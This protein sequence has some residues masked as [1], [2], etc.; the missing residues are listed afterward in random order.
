MIWYNIKRKTVSERMNSAMKAG[1]SIIKDSK[2]KDE[3][4]LSDAFQH[5]VKVPKDSDMYKFMSKFNDGQISLR[6]IQLAMDSEEYQA[7]KD[8]FEFKTYKNEFSI[9][10]QI[11]TRVSF[12]H[13]SSCQNI[14]GKHIYEYPNKQIDIFKFLS[15]NKIDMLDDKSA[16][17]IS[18]HS[19]FIITKNSLD[20]EFPYHAQ[21]NIDNYED[22]DGPLIASFDVDVYMVA[23][24]DALFKTNVTELI[25]KI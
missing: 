2:Q 22:V 17:R 25:I 15:H 24:Q 12:Y 10:A 8:K 1:F 14:H 23:H 19:K 7:V 4:Y 5:S 16:R 11:G 3:M 20:Q 13:M 21:I 18:E 9:S 6:D